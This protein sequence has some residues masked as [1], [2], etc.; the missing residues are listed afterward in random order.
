MGD[1]ML[2]ACC[3]ML[4]MHLCPRPP[5]Q[6]RGVSG[7]ERKRVTS[8]EMLV[9][10]QRVLCMDEISTGACKVWREHAQSVFVCLVS[11]CQNPQAMCVLSQHGRQLMST[12]HQQPWQQ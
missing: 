1:R 11:T 8:G 2:A 5:P 4:L 3:I 7:G 12:L 9:G 6:V 10:N